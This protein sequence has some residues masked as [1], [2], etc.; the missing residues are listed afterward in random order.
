MLLNLGTFVVAATLEVAGYFACWLW[1][2]HGR[3]PLVALVGVV[4][5]IDFAV[6]LTR[7]DAQF[8]GRAYAAYGGIYIADGWRGWKVNGRRPR[9]W[10]GQCW[11]IAGAVVIIGFASR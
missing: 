3:S 2:R 7:V 10:Q 9:T 6:L 11:R 8:A 5:L 1:L 4:S